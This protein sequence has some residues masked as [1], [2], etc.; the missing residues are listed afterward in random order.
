MHMF[1]NIGTRKELFW[2]RWCGFVAEKRGN[3]VNKIK[4]AKLMRLASEGFVDI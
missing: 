3:T 2:T 1:I 4:T